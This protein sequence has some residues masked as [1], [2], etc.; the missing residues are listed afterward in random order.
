[1]RI[2][3]SKNLDKEYAYKQVLKKSR[4]TESF[5]EQA[6]S[7]YSRGMK[8]TENTA[9][10]RGNIL[11]K[12]IKRSDICDNQRSSERSVQMVKQSFKNSIFNNMLKLYL[13]KKP[14]YINYN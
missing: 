8:I 7:M 5:N 4:Q 11:C 2:E 14:R 1:M 10:F 9:A 6:I 12:Y 13:C 3:E